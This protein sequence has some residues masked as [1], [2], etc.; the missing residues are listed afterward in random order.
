[1]SDADVELSQ[2]DSLAT[3]D[4][5]APS[6][7]GMLA[8]A[9]LFGTAPRP[10]G[11]PPDDG[12]G[13]TAPAANPANGCSPGQQP[14]QPAMPFKSEVAFKSEMAF[15]S[16]PYYG[17]LSQEQAVTEGRSG[18]GTQLPIQEKTH[19]N[20]K[21]PI[22]EHSGGASAP[23]SPHEAAQQ[24]GKQG[25]TSEKL[26]KPAGTAPAPP[27]LLPVGEEQAVPA[28]S[29]RVIAPAASPSRPLPSLQLDTFNGAYST[30]LVRGKRETVIGEG[31][32]GRVVVAKKMDTGA[33][34]AVKWAKRGI[35]RREVIVLEHLWRP[36]A[37]SL[38]ASRR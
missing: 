2:A 5:D 12:G 26:P 19:D 17:E 27:A 6:A 25:W 23:A 16:E 35:D 29:G 15:K 31:S 24:A 7:S 33:L 30:A 8:E 34:V 21:Q 18:G 10:E 13:A 9:L 3:D 20:R 28:Q 4:C 36:A 11:A 37:S 1:M 32:E 14:Q 22:A 38:A